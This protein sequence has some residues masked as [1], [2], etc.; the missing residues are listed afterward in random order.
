MITRCLSALYAMAG[1][2][3]DAREA[4]AQEQPRARRGEHAG[5]LVGVRDALAPSAKELAGDRAGAEH[6]LKARWHYFRDILGGA[7]DSRAM[8]AAYRL[9]YL[10]CDDGRWDDA[11]ECL[12][13]H[14][15]VPDA[16]RRD[17]RPHIASPAEARLAAHRGELA[18]AAA[19]AQRAVEI[20]E[21]TDMLEPASPHL[22]RACR[23]AAGRRRGGGGRRRGRDGARALRAERE[24][25]RRRALC[26]S[27]RR[28]L[29]ELR[30]RDGR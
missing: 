29:P 27:G 14:R 3:D 21:A 23:G 18:E 5:H 22:A 12:A 1:R 8:Q 25:R 26:G 24:R 15:D 4:W 6:E 2:F 16:E 9:A 11:E 30:V 10:Y 20:A 17:S 7:P 19:L 13:F 28:A